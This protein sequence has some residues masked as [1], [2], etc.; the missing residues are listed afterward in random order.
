MYVR[1]ELAVSLVRDQLLISEVVPRGLG[2][3]GEGDDIGGRLE[4]EVFV[5]PELA[6]CAES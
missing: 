6:R 2:P 4:V 3:L 5:G 1:V